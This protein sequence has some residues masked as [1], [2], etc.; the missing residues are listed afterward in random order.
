VFTLFNLSLCPSFIYCLFSSFIPSCLLL[1][2]LVVSFSLALLFFF[3][4]LI[5]LTSLKYSVHVL[6]RAWV[7][8]FRFFDTN[9]P[10]QVSSR[11]RSMWHS[12][13]NRK[14]GHSSRL[15]PVN[16]GFL[17]HVMAY[18]VFIYWSIRSYICLLSLCLFSRSVFPATTGG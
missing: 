14:S 7:S 12:Y 2:Y 18:T 13:L 15:F 4:F 8:Y 11:K 17:S 6:K 10:C 1:S 5:F 9:V 3:F 16:F